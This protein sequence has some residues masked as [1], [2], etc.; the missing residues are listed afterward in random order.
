MGVAYQ[1]Q[2]SELTIH[3]LR[4]AGRERWIG[5]GRKNRKGWLMLTGVGVEK[6]TE[7]GR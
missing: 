4:I 2:L 3:K 7:I 5:N 6:V 1:P